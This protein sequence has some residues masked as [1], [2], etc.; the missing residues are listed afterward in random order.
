M[1]DPT[2]WADEGLD[3]VGDETLPDG[4]REPRFTKSYQARI[5]RAIADSKGPVPE[6]LREQ[7]R[8]EE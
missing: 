7:W 2:V 6:W 5:D 3:Y 1:A 4:R 8:K